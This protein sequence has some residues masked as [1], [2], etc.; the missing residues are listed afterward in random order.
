MYKHCTTEKGSYQ[1]KRF[2]Q[3][4]LR[5]MQHIPYDE[6]S[7]RKL[8]EEAGISRKTFYRL[9]TDKESVLC[10]LIDQT[11]TDFDTFDV[12]ET[13]IV[14]DIFKDL[15]LFFLYWKQ[16]KPLLDA[17]HISHKTGLLIE[18]SLEHILRNDFCTIHRLGAD[19]SQYRREMIMF[20]IGGIM[21]LILDW[22]QTG[23]A[24]SIP[25]LAEIFHSLLIHPP[26]RYPYPT[27]SL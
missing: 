12:P 6:I 27:D 9:F 11:Y 17:L 4:L 1:Q 19:H 25:E 5:M 21:T 3:T 18:R 16:Q 7:V 20:H 10:A 24:R 26:I 14:S 15:Q 8:C 23:Y 22:H 2:E 13:D